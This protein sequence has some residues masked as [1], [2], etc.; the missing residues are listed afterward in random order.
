MTAPP[1]GVVDRLDRLAT[2]APVAVADPDVLWRYGR[3][4]QRRLT[5]SLVAGIAA[6]G[7][8][9]TAATP[10][11]L[12][13]IDPPLAAASE[14][15]VLPDV[16]REPGSWEPSFPETPGRLSAVGTGQRS[17]LLS[18]RSALW[19]VSADTGEV[20]WL[21]L[22][23]AVPS[24]GAA[25]QLSADGRRLAYWVTGNTSG[26]PLATGGTE[27]ATP[28]VGLAVMELETGEVARWEVES[29][30]GL[31]VQGLVWAGDVLWWQ[32]GPVVPL[33]G[34][35]SSS[36]VRTHV[37]DLDTDERTQLRGRDERAAVYLSKLGHAP[38]GFV[39]LPRTFRLEQVTGAQAPQGLRVVLPPDAPSAAGLIDPEMSPDGERVAALMLA[40]SPEYDGAA[41]QDLVV[42]T[43]S[44]GVVELAPVGGVRAQAVLGWRS[45]TEV[46]VSSHTAVDDNRV[47]TGQQV[48]VADVETG[49]R[50]DLLD[51]VGALP[52]SVAAEAWTGD[53]VA[54]PDAP[55]APDPRLVVLGGG[56]IIAFLVSLWRSIR[57][58]RG[59][60]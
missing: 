6:A 56:V 26:E 49:E 29:E 23:V 28:V 59:H 12:E 16:V 5:A 52:V 57:G 22:P 53:V 19:G 42:G 1:D 46:V 40:Y 38:G 17:G 35:S 7:V 50:T 31:W 48:S 13:R 21:E 44:D 41:D 27:D 20:R 45:A 34:G 55:F 10:V 4:R 25:A 11:V 8:L 9:A 36:D 15:M 39:T 47:P 32:G 58:R 60:P 33:G 24:A 14:T 37:W 43:R 30:H 18:S 2:Q 51:M 54:A 3:R